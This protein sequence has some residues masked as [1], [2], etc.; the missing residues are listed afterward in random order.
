MVL[1]FR[2]QVAVEFFLAMAFSLILVSLLVGKAQAQLDSNALLG[3]SVL[4]QSALDSVSSAINF[5]YLQ[6]KGSRAE[7]FVF[8]PTG[9][10][11]SG[12]A[13]CFFN[14]AELSCYVG[15][16]GGRNVYAKNLLPPKSE[17]AT[18]LS[19]DSACYASGWM[20]IVV[21]NAGSGGISMV[22]T[23]VS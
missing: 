20:N 17:L 9:V 16:E 19:I 1:K 12:G 10:S 13:S 11:G 6:G 7:V 8:V 21:E 3:K 2:G 18:L 5:V 23:P 15:D 22:C 14:S 4:S